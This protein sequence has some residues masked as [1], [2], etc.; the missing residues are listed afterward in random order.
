MAIAIHVNY[1]P[2]W[3]KTAIPQVLEVNLKVRPALSKTKHQMKTALGQT[4]IGVVLSDEQLSHQ[5]IWNMHAA[6]TPYLCC[7]T[8]VPS[9]FFDQ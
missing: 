1:T 4:I 3:M 6:C 5:F 8:C 7:D 2:R 9:L